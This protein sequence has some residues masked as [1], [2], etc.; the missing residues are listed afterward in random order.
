MTEEE[1]WQKLRE[2]IREEL[3]AYFPKKQR[4]SKQRIHLNGKGFEGISEEQLSSWR[5]AYPLVDIGQHLSLAAAWCYSNMERAPKSQYAR[6]LNSWFLRQQNEAARKGIQAETIG[7]I[8]CKKCGST[9]WVS[10]NA[11][12]ECER[13]R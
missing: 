4:L 13:C 9:S 11:Y 7:R 3:Q 6:F 10:L 12:R 8:K 5:L 2:V 1:R